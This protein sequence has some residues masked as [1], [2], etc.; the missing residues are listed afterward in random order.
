M[1]TSLFGVASAQCLRH[2]KRTSAKNNGK[3]PNSSAAIVLL[4]LVSNK[5]LYRE[6]VA[7][8]IPLRWCPSW[9][10]D[11]THT[12]NMFA[13]RSP[14]TVTDIQFTKYLVES[15]W[16]AFGKSRRRLLRFPVVNVQCSGAVVQP[17]V[18]WKPHLTKH[19]ALHFFYILLVG[20]C[21]CALL[22]SGDWCRW[23]CCRRFV[24]HRQS[25]QK[26]CIA[27]C[28]ITNLDRMARDKMQQTRGWQRRQKY[29][30][31]EM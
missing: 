23:H 21:L 19:V 2:A 31:E 9:A 30:S 6:T 11:N 12:Q 1:F 18:Q 14:V 16:E 13:R 8:F 5:T 27:S 24:I 3:T 28:L 17:Q 15:N 29:F 4:V 10:G 7:L 25:G 22:C 26:Q 20:W